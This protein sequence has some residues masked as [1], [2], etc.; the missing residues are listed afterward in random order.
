MQIRDLLKHRF[1]LATGER[2]VLVLTTI[3]K[4]YYL[5]L[6]AQKHSIMAHFRI[7]PLNPPDA[8]AGLIDLQ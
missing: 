3:A 2:I 1:R 6:N 7:L 5:H 8:T 4:L